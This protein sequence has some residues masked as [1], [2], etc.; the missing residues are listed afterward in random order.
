MD[1]NTAKYKIYKR[2]YAM[3][4][5]KTFSVENCPLAFQCNKRWSDLKKIVT[6]KD[7][8]FC[9]DCQKPVYRIDQYTDYESHAAAGH[10]V[11]LDFESTMLLGDIVGPEIPITIIFDPENSDDSAKTK[12]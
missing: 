5:G 7:I 1:A 2:M 8:R 12:K 3:V 9:S 11:A 10:C 6:E 4:S